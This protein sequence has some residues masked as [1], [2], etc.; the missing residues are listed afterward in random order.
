MRRIALTAA[1]WLAASIVGGCAAVR[2]FPA[3]TLNDVPTDFSYLAGRASQTFKGVPTTVHPAV[4]AALDD[5][6]V[7]NLRQHNDGSTLVFEG[8]TADNRT[9]SVAIKPHP[10]GT[11]RVSSRI[12]LFGDEA[13]SRALM[14]RIAIRLGALPPAAIPTEIPSTP[15][16]NPYFSKSA[17]PDSEMLKD[18]SDAINR[19]ADA[20]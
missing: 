3:S 6:R 9:A 1:A 19:G 16:S 10:G 8:T 15:G 13:L 4:I 12:G 11:S 14:D 20:P 17:I 2:P 18:R 7:I 5:L